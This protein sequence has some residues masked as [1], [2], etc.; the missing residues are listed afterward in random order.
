VT[1]QRLIL[2]IL[3]AIGASFL[4]VVAVNRWGTPADENAYWLAAHR[5]M[6]GQPLYDPTATSITPFAYWYPPIV[7]QV[8]TPVAALLSEDVFNW[9]WTFLMLGCLWWLAGRNLLVALAMCAFPPI[10]VE[11]WFRNVHLILAVLLVLGLRRWGG[12]HSVGAAIKLAPVLGIAYLAMRGRWRDAFVAT[13]FGGALLVVSVA[14]A[15]DAWRQFVDTLLGR[16]PGDISGFLPVPYWARLA[17]GAVLTIVAARLEPRLGEPLLA[18]AVVV[19]LPTLWFT[20][21]S[22][23]AAVVPLVRTRPAPT[24]EAAPR[25]SPSQAGLPA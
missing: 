18:I 22:T 1:P 17:V 14:L 9:A 12:W 21:L 3:A 10:A 6:A 20:A 13:V 7:A 24:T 4:L 16:G 23:L 19:A 5:L 25:P 15:P 11:F 2:I 8:L